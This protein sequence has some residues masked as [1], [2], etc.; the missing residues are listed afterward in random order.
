MMFAQ[1]EPL[2]SDGR[3]D[4]SGEEAWLV[5]F[6]Q[7]PPKP[8]YLRVKVW[9]R[10]QALG[11]I[12]VKNSVYL[13]PL[14][15][16][17]QEDLRWLLREIEQ[18]GGT[19]SICE[20]RFIDGLT[21]PQLREMF[22]AA[23]EADYAET[24]K[25][26]RRLA[27]TMVVGTN[28]EVARIS[29]HGQ[30]TRARRRL[31]EIAA[32]DFF[33]SP[34]RLEAERLLDDIDRGMLPSASVAKE[35]EQAIGRVDERPSLTSVSGSTWVTRRGVWVD[36]MASAWLIRRFIDPLGEFKFVDEKIYTP[37]ESDIRFDMFEAEFTHEGS[38][39][40]FE[41][42]LTY[43]GLKSDPALTAIGEIV[44][45]IDMKDTRFAR[46]ETTGIAV[47]LDGIARREQDDHRRLERSAPVFDDMY[48]SL[49]FRLGNSG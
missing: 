39:C 37:F 29:V 33:D 38:L 44:H 3:A 36:R 8:A 23:R 15:N 20:A 6:H 32:I 13:L 2:Q 47:L 42:L 41:V 49:K 7:L 4:Q 43:T 25:D 12:S 46:E 18:D 30:V 45:D 24:L 27:G 5:M 17:A 16:Q 11:A 48:E 28:A 10:L 34:G 14:N 40:T 1:Q 26:L 22:R 21:S 9:R 19:G 35:G 31:T